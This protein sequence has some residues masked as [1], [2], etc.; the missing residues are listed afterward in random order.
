MR[1][2]EIA[3][4]FSLPV[5]NEEQEILRK[6]GDDGIKETDLGDERSQEVARRMM[7]RGLLNKKSDKR[8]NISYHKNTP[9]YG[10]LERN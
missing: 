2:F 4:G 8:G 3:S 1:Y 5:S 6:I 7:M 9:N 10:W